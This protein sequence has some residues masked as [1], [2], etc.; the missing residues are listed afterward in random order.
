MISGADYRVILN[1]LATDLAVNQIVISDGEGPDEEDDCEDDFIEDD[2][3]MKSLFNTP[4][5]VKL[6]GDPGVCKSDILLK[7]GEKQTK[8]VTLDVQD[9]IGFP[10]PMSVDQPCKQCSRPNETTAS[11]CWWCET[12]N[13]VK[14]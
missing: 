6:F 4:E 11:K 3:F 13:P 14:C 8:I 7:L 10:K 12:E 2:V 1:D 9:F 5:P